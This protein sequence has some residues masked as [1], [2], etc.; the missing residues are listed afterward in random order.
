MVTSAKDSDT[1]VVFV[2]MGLDD[3]EVEVEIAL[4]LH[5]VGLVLLTDL[6]PSLQTQKI[7]VQI[8][9]P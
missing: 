2:D 7:I 3:L 4:L 8:Q 1:C 5:R 6:E 9:D